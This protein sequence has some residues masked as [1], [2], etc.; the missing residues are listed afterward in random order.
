MVF[1]EQFDPAEVVEAV[2]TDG[3]AYLPLAAIMVERLADELAGR[4]LPMLKA[5][6]YGGSAIRPAAFERSA[7]AFP[8]V[9]YQYYGLAE[10][11]APLACLTADDHDRGISRDAAAHA[12]LRSAG[13]WLP[14][15]EYRLIDG[16]L[17]VRGPVV[18]PG[19]YNRPDGGID[20]DGWFATGDL[21]EVDDA[22][23]LFVT[24]RIKD[25]IITG[26]YNVH[27]SEVERVIGALPEIADVVVIGTPNETWGEGI[28]AIV[29][30]REPVDDL[31]G[32]LAA[33]CK[34]KLASYKKP[35]AVHVVDEIPR[36]PA[37]KPNR[38]LLRATYR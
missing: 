15:V 20:S 24:D 19:Y 22:G 8:G 32:Y 12:R 10:A 35:V 26:G 11:L 33:A 29:V 18:M 6:P 14:G 34:A 27:P 3:V 16:E 36:N 30:L 17:A 7:P 9:L 31:L 28:A 21:V 13:T 5:V 1:R 37:G 4:T 23:Y 25:I 38:I 2:T